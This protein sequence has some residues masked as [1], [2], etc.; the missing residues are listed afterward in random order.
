[1]REITRNIAS[2]IIFSRDRKILMW[3]KILDWGWVFSDCYHIPWWGVEK[4]ET[5]KEA[6]I[7]EVYEEVGLDIARCKIKSLS[8]I[9]YWTSEKILKDTWEKV[10][11]NMK[12]NRFEVYIDENSNDIKLKLGGDLVEA[13]WFSFEELKNVKQIPWW[14][15]FFK[16]M[17]YMH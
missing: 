13:N 9:W 10:I 2:A 1:M 17:G 12:F 3:K 4:W 6:M 14:T 11:C 8:E 5:E 15:T 7:R 16:K